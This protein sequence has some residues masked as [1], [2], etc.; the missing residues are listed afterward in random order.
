MKI[1]NSLKQEDMDIAYRVG[2]PDTKTDVQAPRSMIFTFCGLSK[3]Q[4]IM[5]LKNNLK[6]DVDHHKVYVNDDLP[7]EVRQHTDKLRE[8]SN[9]A[10]QKRFKGQSIRKQTIG[11]WQSLPIT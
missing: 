2:V 9:Y 8:I 5:S 3:K 7:I 4:H 1:D 11:K 6:N 10:K